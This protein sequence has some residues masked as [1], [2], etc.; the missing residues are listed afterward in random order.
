[1]YVFPDK[2]LSATPLIRTGPK[3]PI[4][5]TKAQLKIAGSVTCTGKFFPRPIFSALAFDN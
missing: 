5:T 3:L 1:M 2:G 4:F